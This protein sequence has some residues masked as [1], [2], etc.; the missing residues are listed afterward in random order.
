MSK[1]TM[2]Q[3]FLAMSVAALLGAP[4]IHADTFNDIF[5]VSQASAEA[6]QASQAKIDK[7]ADETRDL[8]QEY[9][10]VTKQIDGLK[11]YNAR[12]EK[13]IANQTTRA[14][15][16]DQSIADVTIIQ[17]QITPLVIRMIDGLEEFVALD[18]P[19]HLQ[20]RG[21]RIAFLRN[22]LDRADVTTAEKFRQVLE[23]YKIE[24]E[25]GR[26]I[27]TYKDTITIEGVEREVNVLRVGRVALLY[28][29]PDLAVSGH[30]NV[31][32]RSWEEL[33]SAQYR[34]AIQNGIRMANKQAAIDLL[35]LPV[36]APESTL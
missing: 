32:T 6:G 13:Q 2:K 29:T 18:L 19:F 28:Q 17:R 3:A 24:I 22:N 10:T 33:D 20:E 16:I 11:V 36:A 5:R 14:S 12:L 1:Y 8:L 23:A 7:I 9:K 34:S 15:Q 35:M 26:K 4:S 30:W 31:A 21:D 25:Y 27:D